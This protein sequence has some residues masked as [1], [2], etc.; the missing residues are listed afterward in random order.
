M[1]LRTLFLLFTISLCAPVYAD[2]GMTASFIGAS[3]VGKTTLLRVL[4]AP[5]GPSA[6]AINPGQDGAVYADFAARRILVV[7]EKHKEVM[8]LGK[9]MEMMRASGLMG[10][11]GDAG[12]ADALDNAHD[13]MREKIEE[14]LANMPEGQRNAARKAMEKQ[15]GLKP[16]TKKPAAFDVASREIEQ[17]G[18]TR[19]INDLDTAQIYIVVN[20]ERK[21]EMWVTDPGNINGGQELVDALNALQIL[22]AELVGE[23]PKK[24]G[25]VS[26]GTGVFLG[27]IPD[28]DGFPVLV[29]TLANNEQW[30]LE[31]A[32]LADLTPADFEPPSGYEIRQS[33][34]GN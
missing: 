11:A 19:Q 6:I 26:G 28:V 14:A 5:E 9:M 3:G 18:E 7:D 4:F 25:P 22:F 16:K 13:I 8:D 10:K 27:G 23:L 30:Q 17:T 32:D 15:F 21:T 29:H 24:G 33:L 2:N 12:V 31:Q 34:Q 1:Y 20:G